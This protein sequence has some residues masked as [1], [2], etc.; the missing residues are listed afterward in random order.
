MRASIALFAILWAI[1]CGRLVAGN[2]PALSKISKSASAAASPRSQPGEP[3]PRT[4]FAPEAEPE[5]PET[6]G[7]FE[8][9]LAE[10]EE[11]EVEFVETEPE[12]IITASS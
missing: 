4:E 11:P 8:E 9:P 6:G 2:D 12:P 3:V 7:E 10:I 5:V 1:I